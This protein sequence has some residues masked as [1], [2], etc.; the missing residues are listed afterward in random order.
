MAASTRKK[1]QQIS[2]CKVLLKG[3]VAP[4]VQANI[5]KEMLKHLMFQRNQIPMA[6]EQ[7]K[8]EYE[9]RKSGSAAALLHENGRHKEKQDLSSAAYKRLGQFISTVEELLANIDAVFNLSFVPRVLI[10]LGATAVS[11]KEAHEIVFH[12]QVSV[13]DASLVDLRTKH[14]V[15]ALMRTLITDSPIWEA[16][17]LPLTNTLLLVRAHRDSGL[18][19]FQPKMA[20]KAPTRG[21]LYRCEIHCGHVEHSVGFARDHKLNHGN[22]KCCGGHHSCCMLEQSK[23]EID[24]GTAVTEALVESDDYIWYQAP[25][26]IKGVQ[27]F[28]VKSTGASEIWA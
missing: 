16:K 25:L 1:E 17:Q 12:N 18:S 26:P 21:Q 6:Y 11:P 28:T 2:T 9:R 27:P 3:R 20:L 13:H 23:V 5:V 19:W 15:R 14:C 24:A 7:I 8:C 10:L 22:D 4:H